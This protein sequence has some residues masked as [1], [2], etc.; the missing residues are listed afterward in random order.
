MKSSWAYLILRF[1]VGLIVAIVLTLLLAACSDS[2]NSVTST[3]TN[4]PTPTTGPDYTPL[5]IPTSVP[6]A[7]PLANGPHQPN[8][9]FLRW[10]YY[11]PDDP[12]SQTSLKANLGSLD[13]V[14]PNYFNID[15]NGEVRGSDRANDDALIQGK[16]VKLVPMLQNNPIWDKFHPF[17][18]DP[19]WR[20]KTIA[21]IEDLVNRY[22]YD[23]I[24][25][26]LEAINT[27]DGSAL[28]SFM[29]QLYADLHPQ[30]KLVTM[31][32]GARLADIPNK[33]AGAYDYYK[34]GNYVDYVTI[35]TYDYSYP[36]SD[37]G[38]VAP[39]EWVNAVAEYAA[40]QFGPR[41]VLL[42][43]PFYGYEWNN[44]QHK[45]V[46]SRSYPTVVDLVAKYNGSI[47]YDPIYQS[48]Y[49]DYV[50]DGDNHQIWFENE[51]SLA[52]KF[53]L[54]GTLKL[55]GFAAWRLGQDGPADWT[56]INGA[57]PP[58]A[59]QN[60][61]VTG[62]MYFPAT[63]HTLSATF[64]DYWQQHN[65]L[66]ILGSPLTD[67]ITEAQADG[68]NLQVQYFQNGRLEYHLENKGTPN[69]I[70]PGAVGRELTAK[71]Q[72]EPA[73]KSPL[74]GTANLPQCGTK[75]DTAASC[76]FP[77]TK[78]V[79]ANG[80]KAFWQENG[81]LAVFGLPISQEFAEQNPFDGKIYTVQYFERSLL[82]YDPVTQTLS[83]GELGAQL[84][85]QKG[86]LR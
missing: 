40:S 17:I 26:D 60:Q 23:G 13:V 35:M 79:I 77:Q 53:E 49:A 72:N 54:V 50:K 70:L 81:G 29:S 7:T 44:T 16:N 11:I 42:G 28:T 9:A 51:Q 38:P 75:A 36:G 74:I 5:P 2:S 37:A 6:T 45:Y 69:L 71:R 86:W 33:F 66:K 43:V 41:K 84:L 25:I 57:S 64:K 1:P 24:Q 55:G 12:D 82:Q 21:K 3:T 22:R 58:T 4:V 19:T 8:P 83:V 80:F 34:L 62:G 65:G 18:S 14:S 47:R 52:A 56:S 10:A 59:H 30:G 31:A 73:F 68:T 61:K 76:Y 32:V 67:E 78:Q 39:I 20:S 46:A 85:W 15:A 27:N 48:P 63:G